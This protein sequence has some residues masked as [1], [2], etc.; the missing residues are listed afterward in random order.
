MA[1]KRSSSL[2]SLWER[3][4]TVP[5]PVSI[6]RDQWLAGV[7]ARGLLWG[8]R[9]E[10]GEG[11]DFHYSRQRSDIVIKFTLR[12]CYLTNL[13]PVPLYNETYYAKYHMIEEVT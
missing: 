1:E 13:V 9:W 5:A 2:W 6:A 11:W 4:V 8:S 7:G 12:G 10:F 3:A